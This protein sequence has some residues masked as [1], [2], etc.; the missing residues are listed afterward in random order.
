MDNMGVGRG[1]PTIWKWT[2]VILIVLLVVGGVVTLIA[3]S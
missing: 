2:A 3:I 1:T